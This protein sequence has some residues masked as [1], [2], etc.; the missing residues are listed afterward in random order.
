MSEVK[1]TIPLELTGKAAERLRAECTERIEA[2]VA[3]LFAERFPPGSDGPPIG[4]DIGTLYEQ[5]SCEVS[6]KIAV[7][8]REAIRRD[9]DRIMGQ[10]ADG[11]GGES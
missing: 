1:V 11:E 8:I 7:E 4:F 9:I 3:E 6:A 2:R 5:A 10:G